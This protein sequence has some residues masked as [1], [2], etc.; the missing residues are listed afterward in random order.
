MVD[1]TISSTEEGQLSLAEVF[2]EADSV[3]GKGMGSAL[4]DVWD[5][6]KN[7]WTQFKIDQEANS[8]LVELLIDHLIHPLF[9][10]SVTGRTTNKWSSVTIRL[11]KSLIN[12]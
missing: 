9:C 4:K 2:L 7:E 8:K 10:Y 12:K 1:T 3:S 6:D 5:N 11:G